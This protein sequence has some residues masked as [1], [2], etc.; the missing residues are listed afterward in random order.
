[1]LL[2][3]KHIKLRLILTLL[4]S[5][6]IASGSNGQ[7]VIN[8]VCSYNGNTIEDEDGEESDWIELY[9]SGNL[10]INLEDFV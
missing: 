3:V 7:V 8:E 2:S 4:L 9:N 10:I 6:V 5:G 1:M